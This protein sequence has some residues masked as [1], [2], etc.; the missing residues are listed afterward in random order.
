MANFKDIYE[1]ID[2]SS[3]TE[4]EEMMERASTPL[5]RDTF[6]NIR[7]ILEIS[8]SSAEAN[9]DH[10]EDLNSYLDSLDT[11]CKRLKLSNSFASVDSGEYP[12]TSGDYKDGEIIESPDEQLE[13]CDSNDITNSGIFIVQ[14][15]KRTS[16]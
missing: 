3:E 14:S 2:I 9:A 16:P 1:L 13:E 4:N 8:H 5:P 11:D 7:V 15:H 12:K 10:E 6:P